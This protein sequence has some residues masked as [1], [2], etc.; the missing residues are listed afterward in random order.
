M[1][2]IN[3]QGQ[4]PGLFPKR[5]SKNE[6]RSWIFQALSWNG[7]KPRHNSTTWHLLQKKNIG[8]KKRKRKRMQFGCMEIVELKSKE[9]PEVEDET[10]TCLI[11]A[12]LVV[13]APA[14]FSEFGPL[15]QT[16]SRALSDVPLFG[17]LT[18][19]MQ[20]DTKLNL[21][22][23]MVIEASIVK[24]P[25]AKASLL[26]HS[27]ATQTPTVALNNMPIIGTCTFRLAPDFSSTPTE[28]NIWS[29]RQKVHFPKGTRLAEGD[30]TAILLTYP[31]IDALTSLVLSGYME[32]RDQQPKQRREL[33]KNPGV[34]VRH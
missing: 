2:V 11:G 21:R 1:V 27:A 10:A 5:V 13:R 32:P 29:M 4:A 19:D 15:F 18:L 23:P 14:T 12:G 33:V 28:D 31:L 26:P 24:M 25:I 20:F 8:Q 16:V 30:R 7:L 9:N 34:I 17:V 6:R 3:N 22:S